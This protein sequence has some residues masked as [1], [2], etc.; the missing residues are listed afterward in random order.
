MASGRI[1]MKT[2]HEAPLEGGG[3]IIFPARSYQLLDP[4]LSAKMVADG[5]AV[6]EQDVLDGKLSAETLEPVVVVTVSGTEPDPIS[7]TTVSTIVDEE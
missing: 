4:A 5:H 3:R 6:Y 1:I 7:H 2:A